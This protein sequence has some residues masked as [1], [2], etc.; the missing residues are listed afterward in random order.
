[1]DR[2]SVVKQPVRNVPQSVNNI[3]TV[4]TT[5]RPTS[6]KRSTASTQAKN[7]QTTPVPNRRA[8]PPAVKKPESRS[9]SPRL[10][11]AKETS[12]KTD[13]PKA[14]LRKVDSPKVQQKRIDSPKTSPK[15]SPQKTEPVK[16]PIQRSD[17]FLKEEPTVLQKI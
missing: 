17:T 4:P 7:N 8:T 6:A 2:R 14:Q 12:K 11:K 16:K 3:K 9:A 5:S 10:L 1:M 13:S 15:K